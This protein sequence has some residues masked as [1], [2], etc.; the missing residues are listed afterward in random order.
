M[1]KT[2]RVNKIGDQS[3]NQIKNTAPDRKQIIN[4]AKN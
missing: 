3:L 1:N 4:L 2:D